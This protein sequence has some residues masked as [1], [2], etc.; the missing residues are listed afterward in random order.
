MVSAAQMATIVRLI[1]DPDM[2][3]F[4]FFSRRRLSRLLPPSIHEACQRRKTAVFIGCR[5]QRE[6][7]PH[8]YSAD[9]ANAV[10]GRRDD[11]WGWTGAAQLG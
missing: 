8:Q 7:G 1:D 10:E 3:V 11:E 5:A 2:F 4:P 6:L 9:C